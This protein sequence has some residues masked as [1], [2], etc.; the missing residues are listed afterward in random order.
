MKD[1][2]QILKEVAKAAN[3]ADPKELTAKQV[4]NYC[5]GLL[6]E[7]RLQ[8]RQVEDQVFRFINKVKTMREMQKEYF[9]TRGQGFLQESKRLE[10]E[11][12]NAIE[13]IVK[14]QLFKS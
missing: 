6:E 9:R 1:R 3:V 12:D 14:P 8:Q 4:A 7:Q 5:A 10:K 13:I 11:I 2:N